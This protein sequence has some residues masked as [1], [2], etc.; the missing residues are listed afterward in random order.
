MSPEWPSSPVKQATWQDEEIHRW[1]NLPVARAA[2]WID[3]DVNVKASN[4]KTFCFLR[5]GSAKILQEGSQRYVAWMVEKRH[6]DDRVHQP[7]D[8]SATIGCFVL[9]WS[10]AV[11][12]MQ[13]EISSRYFPVLLDWPSGYLSAGFIPGFLK[14]FKRNC[15]WLNSGV[16]YN[17]NLVS[18]SSCPPR[19][20]WALNLNL[21]ESEA[22]FA[23]FSFRDIGFFFFFFCKELQVLL[24]IKV[25]M[26]QRLHQ[27][28]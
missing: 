6:F 13:S 20:S 7:G 19:K 12:A 10:A 11:N 26:S 5:R 1:V 16:I 8:T 21:G 2:T 17:G 15:Y 28:K 9:L 14:G 22:Q 27:F 25:S 3:K 23:L 4:S 18:H 24:K